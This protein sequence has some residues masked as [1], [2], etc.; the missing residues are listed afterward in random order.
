MKNVLIT[1]GAGF[2]GSHTCI[3]MLEKG[4]NV[5]ILDSLAN[6]SIIIINQIEKII[7]QNKKNNLGK[8]FFKKGD[9]RDISF[10]D[11]VFTEFKDKNISFDSVIHFAGLKSVEESVVNPLIYWEV[12]VISTINLLKIMNKHKCNNLVFSSS[13]T[14]YDQTKKGNFIENSEKKPINPYGNTKLTIERLL[15]DLFKSDINKWKIVNLRYF[16]PVGAHFSGLIGENPIS[17]PTNLF[18]ILLKVVSKEKNELSIYGNDWPTKDGTCI[19]DYIHVMDL[20]D[21]HVAA[22]DFIDKNPPQIISF[23]I[24]T[25]QGTSVLEIIQKFIEVNSVSLPYKFQSRRKGDSACVVADNRFAL[26]KLDWR[27][28]RSLDDMCADSFRWSK[29][30]LKF[31]KLENY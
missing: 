9:L 3:E 7:R 5:C 6:S 8:L 24:G 10:I 29:Y 18:P 25:G 20:A 26:G 4:F 11:S 31:H 13:A 23:N 30:A 1:G 28:K 22:L 16:N 14:I 21:A 12:N 15:S 17:K 2:I 27:P 19:R